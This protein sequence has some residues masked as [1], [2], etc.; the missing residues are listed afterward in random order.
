LYE[1]GGGKSKGQASSV[2]GVEEAADGDGG[3]GGKK[4]SKPK[5]QVD[6]E[7]VELITKDFPN[8][9]GIIYCNSKK[10]CDTLAQHLVKYEIK[11]AQYHADLPRS[12]RTQV[13]RD[14]YAIYSTITQ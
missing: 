12:E 14:W 1:I 5:I 7:I 13:Q 10:D 4:K 9:S 8:E 6:D 3:K 11:A 2:E